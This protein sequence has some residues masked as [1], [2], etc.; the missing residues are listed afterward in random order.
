MWGRFFTRAG[1]QPMRKRPRPTPGR[2]ELVAGE[3][4]APSELTLEML[5]ARIVALRGEAR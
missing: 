2:V 1:G 4:I 5:R 3:P